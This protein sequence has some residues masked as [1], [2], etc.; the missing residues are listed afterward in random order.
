MT[1]REELPDAAVPNNKPVGYLK[2][3]YYIKGEEPRV[4]DQFYLHSL[5]SP[6]TANFRTSTVQEVLDEKTFRTYNSVYELEVLG[7][8]QH[9]VLE[10]VSLEN[11][12]E[13]SNT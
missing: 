2:E 1:K 5:I 12:P 9:E 6:F 8:T 3:G 13:T 11:L 7:E 4:G 10:Y